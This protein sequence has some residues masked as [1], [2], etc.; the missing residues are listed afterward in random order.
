[1]HQIL[2]MNQRSR[3]IL[4]TIRES[5][6]FQPSEEKHAGG[7][8]KSFLSLV[9][10]SLSFQSNSWILHEYS[11]ILFSSKTIGL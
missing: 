4:T 5:D 6:T 10:G 3:D 11:F 8:T 1:M 2:V 7:I 9:I